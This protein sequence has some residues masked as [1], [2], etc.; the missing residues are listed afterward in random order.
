MRSRVISS[1]AANGSSISSTAGS[2]ASARASATRCCMPPDSWCG[3]FVS[4]PV[5]PTT[6]ISS[7]MLAPASRGAPPRL[8]TRSRKQP[9]VAGDLEPRHQ[10]RLLEHEADAAGM[11]QAARWRAADRDCAARRRHQVGDDL[12]ERALAAAG[13][14]DQ[15]DERAVRNLQRDPGQ[16]LDRLGAADTVDDID[17]RH[18]D[19]GA[20]AATGG[21]LPR[22][23]GSDAR[24]VSASLS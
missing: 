21:G 17:V 24:H 13:G 1:S 12:E 22:K 7:S 9:D 5:R 11:A 23:L 15:R 18:R 14:A 3:Y 20:A 19:R 8:A 2:S 10:V 4:N 6:R 16:R